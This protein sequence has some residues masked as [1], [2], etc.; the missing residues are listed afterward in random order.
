MYHAHKLK[1][2]LSSS[3]KSSQIFQFI[4]GLWIFVP[5]MDSLG[6]GSYTAAIT[7]VNRIEGSQIRTYLSNLL[8][9]LVPSYMT[10][11]T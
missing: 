5:A 6:E 1:C 2:L 4:V 9:P 3:P 8:L 11:V 7:L 10:H